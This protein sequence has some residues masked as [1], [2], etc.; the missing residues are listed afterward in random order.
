[1]GLILYSFPDPA[2]CGISDLGPRS[3]RSGK[4]TKGDW[5]WQIGIHWDREC[6]WSRCFVQYSVSLICKRERDCQSVKSPCIV[7]TVCLLMIGRISCCRWRQ[8]DLRRRADWG[9][10]GR[11]GGALF[12][13]RR[14]NSDHPPSSQVGGPRPL[15]F[16]VACSARDGEPPR[17]S[18]AAAMVADRLLNES[19]V[20]EMPEKCAGCCREFSVG[21]K[22]AGHAVAMVTLR[23]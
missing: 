9:A 14:Q 5:P 6:M 12:L 23:A 11:D 1:M 3:T 2:E 18:P 10:V 16:P 13:L 8:S 7:C 15:P 20:E 19:S 22:S 21:M 4:V 17:S